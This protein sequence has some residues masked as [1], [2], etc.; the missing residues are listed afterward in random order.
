[1][2][3]CQSVLASFFVRAAAG[4]YDLT[5]PEQLVALLVGMARNKLLMQARRF[6]TGGRDVRRVAAAADD[7]PAIPDRA[8]GPERHA[9]GRELLGL[10]LDRLDAPEREL[11]QR[12]AVGQTWADIARDLG[13]TP[14]AHRMRLARAVDRVGADL[15]IDDAGDGEGE[16]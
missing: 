6:R 8:P 11:A 7:A 9:V 1:M 5:R 16:S 12:R 2:D 15:G 14:Q 10:L 3:V 13:G 4:Q